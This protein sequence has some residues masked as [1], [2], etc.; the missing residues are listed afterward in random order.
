MRYLAALPI[1]DGRIGVVPRRRELLHLPATDFAVAELVLL[2][3]VAL[4]HAD[5]QD[6]I[7][8]V[9][10]VEVSARGHGKVGYIQ[11]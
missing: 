11:R 5:R 4:V 1:A 8:R 3:H 9:L 7:V 2:E 10:L 6:M